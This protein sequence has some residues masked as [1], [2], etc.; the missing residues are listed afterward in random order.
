MKDD[1]LLDTR[2]RDLAR[3]VNAP[4]PTP[5]AEMWERIQEERAAR[6]RRNVVP[7]RRRARWV[8]W[9][10]GLA[11]TLALGVGLGRLS[12]RSEPTTPLAGVPEAANGAE[13]GMP[14]AYRVATAE[15]LGRVETFLT[16][17]SAE[18]PGGRRLTNADFEMPAR[19]LLRRTR[20]LRESPLV[21]DDV[22]LR[23]LLD[24]VEFVLLQIAAFAQVGDERE[25]DFV[26]QGIT[27]RSVMLRLRS[28]LPSMPARAMVGGSL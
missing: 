20:M 5:R 4:P 19:Q 13:E 14:A 25:L 15:H 10:V 1:E 9:A 22:A 23:A 2:I 17:F 28:T 8:G 21:T 11:A 16:V 3:G 6:R 7:L 12:M 24:D 26:E 27:E 18:A